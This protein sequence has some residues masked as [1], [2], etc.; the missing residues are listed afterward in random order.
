MQQA[1]KEKAFL[2]EI[3]SSIENEVRD[4][5]EEFLKKFNSHPVTTEIE[6]GPS[7]SNTSRTLGGVGIYILTLGSRRAVAPLDLCG[8]YWK[9][10]K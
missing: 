2:K 3:K 8:F 7:A 10:T 6:G 5:Q 1:A 4:A 9:N